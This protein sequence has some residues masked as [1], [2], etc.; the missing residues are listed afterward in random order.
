LRAM[1]GIEQRT[2][3]CRDTRGLNPIDHLRRDVRYAL[4]G[5]IIT[6]VACYIPARRATS[7]DASLAL[8]N[9]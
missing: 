7:V 1:A 5:L 2:E 6:A 4:R 9:D 3:E 8:R